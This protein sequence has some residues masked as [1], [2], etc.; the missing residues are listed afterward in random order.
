MACGGA[1]GAERK[2]PPPTVKTEAVTIIP[3]ADRVEA[4]GTA[5]ANEQVTLSAPVTER[6]VRLTFD[7]GGFVQRNQTVAVLAAGQERAQLAEAQAVSR[8]ANQQLARV[9]ELK[10]R[11]FATNASLDQQVALSSAARA[12][13][14]EA[15]ASIGER[16]ITVPFSG[17]VSLRSISPVMLV[18]LAAKNG[19]FIVEFANQLRDRGRDIATAIREASARHLRPILMTSIATAAGAVPLMIASGSPEAVSRKLNQQ[20]TDPLPAE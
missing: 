9:N 16:V 18:G 8:N 17:R 1:E 7:E 20:L 11:G 6:L 13:A 15:R 14:A 12:R 2:R 19:I 4:V 5:T 3:F 10:R